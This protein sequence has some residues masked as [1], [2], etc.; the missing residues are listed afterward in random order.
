MD[1]NLQ[2]RLSRAKRAFS[3]RYVDLA[4]A[5][6]VV[7]TTPCSGDLVLARVTRIGNHSKLESPHGRRQSLF[8]GD[9]VVV[10]YGHRY[11]PDQFEAS[12]P[13]DLGPC[14]LVAAGGLAARVDAAHSAMSPATALEPVGLLADVYGRK[15]NLR[16]HVDPLLGKPARAPRQETPVVLAVVGAAMNSGKTT[17]AA[18][19]VRGLVAAGLRV[20]AA[21]VTGTGAGGDL[22]LLQDSGAHPV[23]DFTS[24]G[25]ASTYRAGRQTVVQTFTDLTDVLLGA[26]LDVVVVEVA[27]GLFQ[28]ESAQLLTEDVF[29]TRVDGVL[30]AAPDALA[31]V[32]GLEWLR[33]NDTPVV[34]VTG[35]LTASPL[36][37]REAAAHTGHEVWGLSRLTDPLEA[38]TL[39]SDLL[40]PHVPAQVAALI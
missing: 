32:A 39:V 5:A 21:K 11:A 15:L 16:D 40:T 10:A 7:H 38:M 6:G 27:D 30:F 9:E 36:A 33:R 18:G 1:Q 24:A 4:E 2:R 23:L 3:T 14:H 13:D 31:A 20:G 19:L 28:T 25:L 17:S 37:S 29:R 35:L 8:V 26:E 34:G 12:V 22:W